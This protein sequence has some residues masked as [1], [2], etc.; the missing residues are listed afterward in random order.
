M[1]L[2]KIFFKTVD[3]FNNSQS[4]FKIEKREDFVIIGDGSIL[5][6]LASVNFFTK[7]EKN[8][9]K[10]HNKEVDIINTIFSIK[11]EKI[12]NKDLILLLKDNV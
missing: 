1:E 12:T 6:S 9:F 7:L 4:Q 8:I 2:E 11:K 10:I 3:D 5:D